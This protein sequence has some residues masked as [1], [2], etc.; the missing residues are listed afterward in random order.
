MK[1]Y[2]IHGKYIN[3]A[4]VTHIEITRSVHDSELYELKVHFNNEKILYFPF[5][6]NGKSAH[7]EVKSFIEQL[8]SL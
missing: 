3:L 6:E 5:Y 2:K 4:Q 8:D 1:F 7:L